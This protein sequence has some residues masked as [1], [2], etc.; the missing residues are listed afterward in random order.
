MTHT[1]NLL[2]NSFFGM[3]G[4][5]ALIGFGFVCQR[6]LNMKLGEALVGLNS[7]ISNI[8]AILSVSELG[9]A[10]AVVYNLYHALALRNERQIA[11]L[12]NFYRRAY[13]VFAAVITM[14]GLAVMPFLQYFLRENPF[15]M[16]YVRLIYSLWLARTVAAYL[17]SYQRSILIADQQEYIVS[18]A[19]LAANVLDYSVIIALVYLTGDFVVPLALN[20][21]IDSISNLWIRRVVNRKYPFLS[22]L[23][24]E[25]T[26]PALRAQVMHNVKNIFASHLADKLLVATDNVIISSFISVA[27]VGLYNN[28]CLVINALTNISRALANAIQPSIGNLFVRDHREGGNLLR[29]MTFL[30]FLIASSSGCAVY[31]VLSPFV[32]DVWLG[33]GYLL[34]QPV[35]AACVINYVAL[36]LGLPLTVMM[37][38]TGL[39]DRERNIAILSAVC[40]MVL[41]LG[42]V[43]ASGIY[44]VLAGTLAAYVLQIGFRTHV[45][46]HSYLQC[47]MRTYVCD[48]SEYVLLCL[49][50]TLLVQRLSGVI[51]GNGG[52]LRL[53]LLAVVSAGVPLVINLVIFGRSRR[54]QGIL[55]LLRPSR[56]ERKGT[57]NE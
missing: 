54:M 42:L 6:V 55:S 41:S 47:T 1:K 18:I 43:S 27:F 37:G 8:L 50:E 24:H 10:T 49:V 45:F 31:H 15:S 56:T 57:R 40:N 17:L 9:I 14:L 53:L 33:T 34:E 16:S 52:W 35:V 36:L 13:Y 38:V 7:V 12:M 21:V 39:F 22:R 23:R 2:R 4:Q 5:V 29:V 20:I 28:Y 32:G 48:L 25:K 26:N 51:Y 11:A 19:V 30:F 3:L 44:G 46:H